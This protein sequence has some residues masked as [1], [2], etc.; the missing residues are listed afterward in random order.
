MNQYI[1]SLVLNGDEYNM[2]VKTESKEA[3]LQYVKDNLN[4]DKIIG[5]AE[6]LDFKRKRFGYLGNPDRTPYGS[7]SKDM[8]AARKVKRGNIVKKKA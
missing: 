1:V 2:N 8:K 7:R 6:K 3:A 4:F 5:V